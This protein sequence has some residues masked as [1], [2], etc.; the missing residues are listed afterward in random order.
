MH[1]EG[2]GEP[3]V[4]CGC[5]LCAIWS[6][7]RNSEAARHVRAIRRESLLLVRSLLDAGIRRAE[8]YLSGQRRKAQ[9]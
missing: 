6:A 7:Y 1:A 5:P 9:G 8:E 4:R 3:S 2:R